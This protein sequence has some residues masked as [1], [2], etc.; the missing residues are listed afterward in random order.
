MMFMPSGYTTNQDFIGFL[1]DGTKM[2]FAIA[3]D[4]Y[5]YV[6]NADSDEALSA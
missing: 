4:Y 6:S 3:N 1:P 5:E 2:H